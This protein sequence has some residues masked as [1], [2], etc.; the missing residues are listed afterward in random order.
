IALRVHELG[1]ARR[2]RRPLALHSAIDGAVV[3][4]ADR[5]AVGVDGL[6]P[7]DDVSSWRARLRR[8]HGGGRAQ[9]IAGPH[10]PV[11]AEI[12]RGGV[13]TYAPG[14]RR[15]EEIGGGVGLR[16]SPARPRRW[17]WR[18]WVAWTLRTAML[19]D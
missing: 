4:G 11:D 17:M 15:P 13:T 14:G 8:D 2:E 12:V 18:S 6:E 19:S 10:P 16:R 3:R 5:A 1:D 7:G 9:A